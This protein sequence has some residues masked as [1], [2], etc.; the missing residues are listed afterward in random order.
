MIL[1]FFVWKNKGLIKVNPENVTHLEASKNYT[2]VFLA[3]G[4]NVL[5]R[6]ALATTLKQLPADMF[7]KTHR[8]HAVSVYFID[9]LERDHITIGKKSIPV[10]RSYYKKVIGALNVIE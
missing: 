3:G 2:K 1:P 4:T 6:S 10:G 8:S 9:R 5:V 7:I